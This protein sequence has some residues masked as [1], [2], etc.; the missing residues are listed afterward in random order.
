MKHVP[1]Q[2]FILNLLYINLVIFPPLQMIS[3]FRFYS[4]FPTVGVV[5]PWTLSVAFFSVWCAVHFLVVG[6]ERLDVPLDVWDRTMSQLKSDSLQVDNNSEN[7]KTTSKIVTSSF[8]AN[9]DTLRHRT[10]KTVTPSS[11]LRMPP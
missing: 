5:V 1:Y 11:V 4:N 2:T 7:S 3:R 8:H 9:E 6:P 10:V